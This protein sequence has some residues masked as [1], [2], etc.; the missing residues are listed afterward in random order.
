MILRVPITGKL[1]SYDPKTKI[2]VGDDNDVIRPLDLKKLLPK[3]ITFRWDMVS[4]DYENGMA[5]IEVTFSKVK[6]VTEW[7]NSKDPPEEIAWRIEKDAE[8]YKR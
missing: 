7:D 5:I 8:F 4:C 1:I 2:G 3:E 6:T